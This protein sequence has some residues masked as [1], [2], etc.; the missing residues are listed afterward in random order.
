MT[1]RGT[2]KARVLRLINKSSSYSGFH[3]DDHVNDAI[4]DAMD[5][6]IAKTFA[7]GQG[8]HKTETLLDTVAG[9]NTV[10]LPTGIGMIDDVRYLSNDTYVSI[11]YH[12][13]DGTPHLS[14]S[15][16]LTQFPSYFEVREGN[17]YFNP[18]PSEVGTGY[19]QVIHY[20]YP[21]EFSTDAS[22][23]PAQYSRTIDQF[24]KW[25]AATQLMRTAGKDMPEWV[26]EE[27]RWEYLLDLEL[28][29]R[30]KQ[31]QFVLDFDC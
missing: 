23:I 26:E 25:K 1:T 9:S 22:T 10:A 19:V 17:L 11:P 31:K 27:R 7:G 29:K 4:Q 14:A 6:V 30:I 18:P 13:G 16:T 12:D 15:G 21:A 2:I 20:S 28:A 5:L 24:V 3:T 8:W